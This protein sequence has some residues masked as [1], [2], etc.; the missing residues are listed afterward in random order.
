MEITAAQVK[1]LRDRT[2]A[3]MME[4]KR[5]LT[6]AGGDTAEAELVLRRQGIASAAKKAARTASEGSIGTYIHAGGKLGVLLEIACE[7]DFVARTD[8]FQ[9]LLHDVAM[10][11]AAAGPRYVSREQVPEA[12]LET[13]REVY[14]QQVANQ[15][16]GKPKPPAVIE[17]IVEGKLG[18]F[19]EENCLLDQHFVKDDKMTIGELVASKI[20]KFGENIQVRRYARYKV[21]DESASESAV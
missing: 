12:V 11:I 17:K 13:E 3:P 15:N 8:E 7:S 18:K 21:G 20:A 14:R 2:G 10:H 1:S 6:A 5:A 4:C 16:Q 19:F 9:Q